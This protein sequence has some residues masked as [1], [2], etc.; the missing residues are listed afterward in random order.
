MYLTKQIRI[1][2]SSIFISS[3]S[4]IPVSAQTAP[5]NLPKIPNPSPP[6]EK[7]FR[8]PPLQEPTSPLQN[9]PTPLPELPEIKG[10]IK[11][12]V[13]RINIIGN[14]SIQ[15]SILQNIVSRYIGKELT[16]NDLL[17]ARSEISKYYS[18]KGYETSRA[19]ILIADN[20]GKLEQDNTTITI[21][22][23]EGEIE[24]TNIL[25]T[26]HQ[27]SIIKN[28]IKYKN[29]PVL[30]V[31]KLGEAL[32][33]LQVD[34]GFKSITGE[35]TQGSEPQN[36]V[37]TIKVK[38]KKAVSIDAE[39]SNNAPESVGTFQQSVKL[40]NSN[41]FGI[42]DKFSLGVSRTEGSESLY[43][44]LL[45][46]LNRNNGT[47]SLN[48]ATFS[49][50]IILKPFDQLNITSAT[51]YWGITFRQPVYRSYNEKR[52]REI[53]TGISV[54]REENQTSLDGT[55]FQLSQGA[56][57]FGKT[58]S[59][60]LNIFGDYSFQSSKQFLYLKTEIGVGLPIG[61]TLSSTPPDGE[62]I[63]WNSS[64]SWGRQLTKNLLF[65]SGA[66]LQLADRPLI[67]SQQVGFGGVN[68]ISG[69]PT[70]SVYT[71]NGFL[72]KVELHYLIYGGAGGRLQI[73]PGFAFGVPWNNTSTRATTSSVLASA[74][75]GLQYSFLDRLNAKIEW[76]IPLF[77]IDRS[78]QTPQDQ[79]LSLSVGVKF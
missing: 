71:D 59:T 42:G 50:R 72:A 4:A 40:E 63:K 33:L 57:V 13:K 73:I 24:Q 58:K 79:R 27:K 28:R 76:G 30:N 61:A 62:F 49:N 75:L 38:P 65:F 67:Q 17:D 29:F 77:N 60:T 39:L 16:L 5:Q 37:V 55:P 8:L 52:F 11:L 23:V 1:V 32:H 22:C 46:P 18:E 19:F 74:A 35:F 7:P 41:L 64:V 25:G 2:F 15:S 44:N 70:N 45:F 34:Y 43:T 78:G 51:Q 47:I 10:N 9:S 66:N 68:T 12:R 14:N 53:A 3:L 69:Y 54:S 6:I 56:D 20:Q 21:R 36:S 31:L 26:K 48:Y